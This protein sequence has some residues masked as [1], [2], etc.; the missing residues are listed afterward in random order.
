VGAAD[1]LADYERSTA[2]LRPLYALLGQPDDD[3]RV[4][5]YLSRAGTTAREVVHALLD[6]LDVEE[7]LRAGGVSPEELTALR[8]R[9]VP[10]S[11]RPAS[12]Q[13]DCHDT[14]T[15]SSL[16]PPKNLG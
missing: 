5:A 14:H 8:E 9:L 12:S 4:Q 15:P 13:A 10:F 2:R 1:I 3:L 16:P 7:R 6:G 11:A